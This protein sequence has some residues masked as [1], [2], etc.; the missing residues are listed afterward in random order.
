M[1]ALGK[2]I[3]FSY[4]NTVPGTAF[5]NE[6]GTSANGFSSDGQ[7]YIDCQPV[8]ESTDTVV[9]TSSSTSSSSGSSNNEALI[10]A[11]VMIL[12]VGL[13]F[14]FGYIMTIGL[15]PTKDTSIYSIV[16]VVVLLFV[17]TTLTKKLS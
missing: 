8:G 12:I 10:G 13:L 6:K 17:V 15:S 7:I 11:M 1:N 3:T 14:L 4:I 5:Y 16:G 2:L 9:T